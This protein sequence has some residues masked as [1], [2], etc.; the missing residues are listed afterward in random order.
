[1]GSARIDIKSRALV[2]MSS[3]MAQS[4]A[5]SMGKGNHVPRRSKLAPYG[6]EVEH[7]KIHLLG[8]I[9]HKKIDLKWYWVVPGS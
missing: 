5:L 4:K 6:N 1:M 2:R 3:G 9:I 7:T 8:F